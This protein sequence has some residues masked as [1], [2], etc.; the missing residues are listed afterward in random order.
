L[1]QA[2][3]VLGVHE[4]YDYTAGAVILVFISV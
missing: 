2:Q 1:A 4:A 3:V